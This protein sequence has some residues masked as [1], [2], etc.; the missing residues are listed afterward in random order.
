M[1]KQAE[2]WLMGASILGAIVSAL[3]GAWV[4]YILNWLWVMFFSAMIFA[5]PFELR[6]YRLV[7][8]VSLDRFTFILGEYYARALVKVFYATLGHLASV[9]HF[10]CIDCSDMAIDLRALLGRHK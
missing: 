1:E 7:I 6:L 10:R 4:F 8:L 2:W 5:D 9:L 3:G